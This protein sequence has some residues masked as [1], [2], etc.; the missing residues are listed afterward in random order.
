[1]VGGVVRLR[2]GLDWQGAAAG[3]TLERDPLGLLSRATG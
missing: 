1:V 2:A 3:R